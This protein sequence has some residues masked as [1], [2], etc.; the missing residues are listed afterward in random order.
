M[1]QARLQDRKALLR[2]FDA[3][4]KTIEATAAV[5]GMD[6]F[7]RRAFEVLSSNK[8]VN[9]LDVSR[10]D[11]RLRAR[12]GIGDMNHIDDGPPCCMDQFLMARRLVEAGVRCVTIGFGRWDYHDRNFAQCR[13]RLPKLDMALSA[14]LEDLYQRGME[15]DVS[16]VVWGE[17]GRTPRINPQGG[18]DHWP[19]VSCAILAGGGL[20]TGQV[21]GQTNANGEVPKDRP[22]TFQNVFAT[23]YHQL[24]IE[25]G[26]TISDPVGRPMYLLDDF[27]PI[28]E[29]I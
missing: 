5:E 25:P 27:T 26:T 28:H 1:S 15:K 20:R 21:I 18:R 4:R 14:L 7:S 24:G 2:T 17:F 3:Y 8:L 11:P 6:E 16:V 10:E 13:E 9:A 19:R 23:L 12:Y 22:I 29:L